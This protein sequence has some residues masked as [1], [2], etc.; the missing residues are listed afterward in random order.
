MNF[1]HI[2]NE[3]KYL[4]ENFIQN[5]SNDFFTYFSKRD[6]TCINNHK[7]TIILKNESEVIGYGHIDYEDNI[8]WL[9]ICVLDKFCG[10]GY[11]KLIMNYLINYFNENISNN[12]SL[13]LCVHTNNIPALN[14]Y[15]KF[16]F[17]IIDEIKA[18]NFYK[19]EY[20]N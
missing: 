15:K 8:H 17:K 4:L 13:Y 18:K 1:I 19:M 2:N 3:N 7:L 16:N 5:I 11:G 12:E 9:G 14:L 20:S 6:I 10:N